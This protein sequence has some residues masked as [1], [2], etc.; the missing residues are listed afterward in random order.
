MQ[1]PFIAAVLVV[2]VAPAVRAEG[3]SEESFISALSDDHPALL[4]LTEGVARAEAARVRAGT[5]A[6]P[7]LDFW[8]EEPE[9]NPHV[10]N[11][12]LSWTPPLDGRY[13][14][15]K[16]AAEAGLTAA[17]ER[18][19]VERAAMR[20]EFREAFAGWSLALETRQVLREQFDLIATLAEY[21]RQR[22]RTGEESGLA[23]R[24]FSLAEGEARAALERAE[25][26][27]A[28]T[29]AAARAL[30]QDLT[31]EA[32]PEPSPLPEPPAT[33]DPG[34]A[35]QLRALESEKEQAGYEMRRAGRY[36]GFPTLL[37]GWQT[38]EDRDASESG[39]IVAAG[40]TVPLFDRD[41]GS[42]LE[43]ERRS[44]IAAARLTFDQAR[45]T[46]EIEGGLNAYRALFASVRTAN[47]TA[48]ETDK[49]IDAAT[50]A[51]RAGESDLTDLLETLRSAFAARLQAI[52]TR[53]HALEAHRDLEAV[54]GR[55][56][57]GGG[58]R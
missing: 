30:R 15:G 5:L 12:T 17:R 32:Q 28:R 35:P 33:L 3:V 4:S 48:T 8:R 9:S 47:E 27:Y 52:D 55:P 24:R 51:Y 2:L 6:N 14:L 34:G 10:T 21:E 22:A 37:L 42:R 20:R 41:Q 7:R 40:W 39:P 29:E 45:L 43:A 18:F 25:A 23:A 36:F 16:K 44:E 56:L 46:G 54:L 50:A 11:W 26:D 19:D 53:A 31:A 49:I 38:L 13:G 58:E 57:T 1:R